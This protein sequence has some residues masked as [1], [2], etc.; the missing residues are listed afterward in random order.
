MNLL[1]KKNFVESKTAL[2]IMGEFLFIFSVEK[3]PQF[4]FR[5]RHDAY[6]VYGFERSPSDRA[7]I[8][9]HDNLGVLTRFSF[10]FYMAS[11]LAFYFKTK[12]FQN[13]YYFFTG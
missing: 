11:A 8:W 13:L 12:F 5:N 7:V 10:H 2:I 6:I 3:V 1:P 4:I 9:N